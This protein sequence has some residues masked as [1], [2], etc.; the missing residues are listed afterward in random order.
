MKHD[1]ASCRHKKKI[2]FSKHHEAYRINNDK[3]HRC[4]SLGIIPAALLKTPERNELV[5]NILLVM[6]SVMGVLDALSV[7]SIT[8]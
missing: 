3:Q 5:W 7:L 6:L 8:S 4:N 2:F 1:I